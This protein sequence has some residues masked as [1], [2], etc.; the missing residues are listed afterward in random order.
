MSSK[1]RDT[2]LM[3]KIRIKPTEQLTIISEICRIRPNLNYVYY[4][5]LTS[6]TSICISLRTYQTTYLLSVPFGHAIVLTMIIISCLTVLHTSNLACDFYFPHL[7]LPITEHQS[8]FIFYSEELIN[9]NRML[10]E[11]LVEKCFFFCLHHEIVYA[12][13]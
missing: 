3:D 12:Y 2:S 8:C 4:I 1:A 5:L 7:T 10:H 13:T 9:G 6:Q 11:Y